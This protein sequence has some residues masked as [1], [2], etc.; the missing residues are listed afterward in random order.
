MTDDV[1]DVVVFDGDLIAIG[2]FMSAGGGLANLVAR[3]DGSAWH[4]LGDGLSGGDAYVGIIYDEM[5][6]VAGQFSQAGGNPAGKIATWDGEDWRR[7]GG[8]PLRGRGYR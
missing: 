5:L 4:P 6:V 7:L 2:Q 8:G 3:W 1:E